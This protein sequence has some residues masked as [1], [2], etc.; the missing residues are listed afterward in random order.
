MIKSKKM[1]DKRNENI[2]K[3]IYIIIFILIFISLIGLK[4][5]K[6]PTKITKTFENVLVMDHNNQEI[7]RTNIKIDGCFYN[8]TF[9]WEI[10]GFRKILDG[11]IQIGDQSYYLLWSYMGKFTDNVTWGSINTS[12]DEL[13]YKYVFFISKDTNRIYIRSSDNEN[14]EL[15][16]PV[17]TKQDYYAL[18]SEMYGE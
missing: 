18:K 15:M 16:Y 2:R 6:T 14:Y 3:Y 13:D 5:Y 9:I 11:N 7:G 17:N 10:L 12:P 4:I 8:D 1:M